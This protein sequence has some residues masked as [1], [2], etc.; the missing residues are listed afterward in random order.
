MS[1]KGFGQPQPSKTDKLVQQV[2]RHCQKRHLE[3]LDQIFDN[4]PVGRT[5][6]EYQRLNQ[7]VLTGTIDAL[8]GDIDTL[9]WFCAY[10]ASEI[11]RSEDNHKPHHPIKLLSKLLIKQK[12][13][14]FSDFMPYHGCRI[15]IL[16]ADKFEAL[17]VEVRNTVQQ[18][19]DVM[20]NSSEQL[21][22]INNA[23]LEELVVMAE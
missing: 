4:L 9:A 10:S 1:A 14:P 20:E 22:Q 18:A 19:F 8:T 5:A 2:V 23:L 21:Q 7:Q 15:V 13:Q 17:P 6:Q 16:N 11:N 12:M 3:A